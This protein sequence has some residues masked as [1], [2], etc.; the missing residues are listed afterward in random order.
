MGIMAYTFEEIKKLEQKAAEAAQKLEE[1]RQEFKS[2]SIV[3]VKEEIKL[4]GL[5]P[6]ELFTRQEIESALDRAPKKQS[7]EKPKDDD[8]KPRVNVVIFRDPASG[9]EWNGKGPTI[10]KWL[11]ALK[12]NGKLYKDFL[13]EGTKW[14]GKL[15]KAPHWVKALKEEGVSFS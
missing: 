11:V 13:V 4:F 5:S 12:Q 1:A 7:S 6:L 15:E 2:V 3:K 9:T 10:P 8:A 14:N